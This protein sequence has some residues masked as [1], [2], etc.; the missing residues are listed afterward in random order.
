MLER[1]GHEVHLLDLSGV[2]NFAEALEAHLA[3]CDDLIFGLT[4]TTPQLPATCEIA[5][6]IRRARPA[7]RLILGG[8]HV[9]LTMAAVK[10]EKKLGR[11]QFGR[12][13]QAAA[14]L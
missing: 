13:S 2:G 7:A 1:R 14:R 5:R 9:T 3:A 8:P 10:L 12:A 6:A 4:A 11:T